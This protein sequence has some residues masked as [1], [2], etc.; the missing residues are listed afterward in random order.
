MFFL[1][2]F[3]LQTGAMRCGTLRTEADF[4]A[5]HNKEALKR[6]KEATA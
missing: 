4:N 6:L 2:W 1:M 3:A 5:Q